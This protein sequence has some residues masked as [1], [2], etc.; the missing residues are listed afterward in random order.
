[1]KKLM[2]AATVAAMTA[3]AF[4]DSTNPA[5][6]AFGNWNEVVLSTTTNE[7]G[8][9]TNYITTIA[10]PTNSV[11]TYKTKKYSAK[12]F[13][14]NY[15]TQNK[16]IKPFKTAKVWEDEARDG[17][18][19]YGTNGWT[20]AWWTKSQDK[21]TF[22]TMQP[23]FTVFGDKDG[24]KA[25]AALDNCLW[26]DDGLTNA[27]ASCYSKLTIKKGAVNQTIK[28]L[29]NVGSDEK[30]SVKNYKDAA[31]CKKAVDKLLKKYANSK[32]KEIKD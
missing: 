13:S 6:L 18:V 22:G 28:S 21:G 10:L 3:G 26:Y 30:Y 5:D 31:A 32:A 24:K 23:T 25:F 12:A 16:K 4:A 1:M 20:V 19:Y 27:Y 8:T 2:I 9:V 17:V 29:K 7:T 11:L 14:L 15:Q